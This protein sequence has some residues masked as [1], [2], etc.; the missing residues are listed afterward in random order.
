MKFRPLADRFTISCCGQ[1][2]GAITSVP[3]S[4]LSNRHTLLQRCR[5]FKSA[6]SPVRFVFS[7]ASRTRHATSDAATDDDGAATA[8]LSPHIPREPVQMI[9]KNGDDLRQDQF[10]CQVRTFE[11]SLKSSPSPRCLP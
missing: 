3:A 6:R 1:P 9:F 4:G 5:V 2:V 11:L 8:N 10:V 7:A